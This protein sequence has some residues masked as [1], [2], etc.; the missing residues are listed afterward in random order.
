MPATH[1]YK[2]LQSRQHLEKQKRSWNHQD[3][4]LRVTKLA[5]LKRKFGGEGRKIALHL[6]ELDSGFLKSRKLGNFAHAKV[7]K[8][9]HGVWRCNEFKKLGIQQRWY[10]AKRLSFLFHSLGADHSGKTCTRTRIC[11]MNNCR[12]THNRLL[13]VDKSRTD[14]N[15]EDLGKTETTPTHKENRTQDLQEMRLVGMDW[16]NLLQT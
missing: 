11:A 14:T 3:I 1:K 10:T 6:E 8:G 2:L 16:D 9:P 4:L 12:D 13:H 5:R 7:C 15:R